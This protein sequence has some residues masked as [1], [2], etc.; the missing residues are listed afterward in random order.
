[1][2]SHTYILTAQP[3]Q[4]LS[5]PSIHVTSQHQHWHSKTSL[6]AHFLLV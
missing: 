3:T 4:P 6:V 2:L 1:M 5:V